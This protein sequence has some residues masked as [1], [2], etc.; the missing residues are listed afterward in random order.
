VSTPEQAQMQTIASQLEELRQRAVGDGLIVEKGLEFIDDGY[1]G[2]TLIRP[3][4]E[5]LRDLVWEGT[6]DRVYV[7][8]PDRLARSFAYQSILIEELQR[9]GVEIIFLNREL[10]QTPEDLLLLQVQGVIAE[11][12]RAKI[13]ERN[14]RG[15]RH[16]ARCG[17][18]SALGGAPYGYQY[19]KKQQEGGSAQYEVIEE[20]AQVVRQI[21][22]WIAQQ[23][24]S[25]QEICRR[26]AKAGHTTRKGNSY[27]DRGT[28]WGILNNP[29]Y[30]GEAIF[31]KTRTGQRRPQLRPA[32]GRCAQPKRFYSY[33]NA[34]PEDWVRIPVPA[35][36]EPEVFE[37]V[38]DQLQRNQ[39]RSRLHPHGVKY[40]L[41]GLI[42]C[43][44][45]GYAY[46]GINQ[47]SAAGRQG[48]TYYRCSGGDRHRFGGHKLC[49]N[50]AVRADAL[51]PAVWD[52]V[53]ALLE[54]P[55]RLTDEYARRLKA[56]DL[57]PELAAIQTR[58]N[59]LGQLRWRLIDIY[60]EGLIDKKEFETRLAEARHRLSKMQLEAEQIATEATLQKELRL[61]IGRLEDF[62][63][64]ISGKLNEADWQTKR[65]LIRTLV[66]RVD[67]RPEKV[68][69][70]FRVDPPPFDRRPERGILQDCWWTKTPALTDSR[71]P[72][73][74]TGSNL[75]SRLL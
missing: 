63:Q 69:I 45:C 47:K 62:S 67:V 46:S 31:G 68:D 23:R 33:Y 35:I 9:S 59:H 12:E 8:S 40:L 72:A 27:W 52:E 54:Q 3:A 11:Y 51:E 65:D 37:A 25:I 19:V 2:S 48:Y 29:A 21:F 24:V 1:S 22:Q 34:P 17:K 36:V 64:Q 30:K 7:H 13:I 20:Q 15:R 5:R 41:Q 57:Q 10:K 14:R 61:I 50:R 56:P 66:K 39:H 49:N 60:T 32:R 18:V 43:Q 16:A 53:R 58:I 74:K 26:L 4:L 42:S 75:L 6:V 73:P 28:I 70:V 55:N 71:G 38:Q 44:Q